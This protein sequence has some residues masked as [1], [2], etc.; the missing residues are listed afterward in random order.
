MSEEEFALF[1]GCTIP[2]RGIGYEISTRKVAKELGIKLV[3]LNF[4]CCGYPLKSVDMVTAKS[5]AT[6]NLALAESKKLNVL[7]ICM[8]AP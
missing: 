4:S 7:T 8:P 3:D 1:L 2:V 5:M 6:A